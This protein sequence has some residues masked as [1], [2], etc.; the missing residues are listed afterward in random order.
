MKVQIVAKM[1]KTWRFNC[2]LTDFEKV[3]DVC[4]SFSK[5]S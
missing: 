4:G 1:R 3:K 5:S 2:V